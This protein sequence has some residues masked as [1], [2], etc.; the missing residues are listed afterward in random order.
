MRESAT[1]LES[2]QYYELEN[3]EVVPPLQTI[4][5]VLK[6]KCPPSGI[7]HHGLTLFTDI[8]E[9]PDSIIGKTRPTCPG[10]CEY[11]RN[12][13]NQPRRANN[14]QSAPAKHKRPHLSDA[15]AVCMVFASRGRRSRLWSPLRL[16]C[17]GGSAASS[18]SIACDQ[19]AQCQIY[20]S[21]PSSWQWVLIP[22]HHT[23][24]VPDTGQ[25]KLPPPTLQASLAP[26]PH[27]K[28]M[29]LE[30]RKVSNRSAS[31]FYCWAEDPREASMHE[32]VF[33]MIV[34]RDMVNH[35]SR[36]E[37]RI[38]LTS[39]IAIYCLNPLNDDDCP[40]GICPNPD[41]AGPLVRIA[42]EFSFRPPS[43][44]AFDLPPSIRLRYGILF[45]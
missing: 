17:A 13:R 41:I 7:V 27:I 18:S 2:N 44:L 34:D 29:D 26:L 5:V 12:H 9:I 35:F 19:F 14:A 42:R 39:F 45:E 15:E 16:L 22:K 3:I 4:D 11:T 38:D 10:Q 20:P 25:A 37:G 36:P 31:A 28:M 8:T 30:P 23:V 43:R 1:H 24:F 6:C 40:V 33:S 32:D 21:P